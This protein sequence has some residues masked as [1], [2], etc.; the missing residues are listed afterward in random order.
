MFVELL[1]TD[2]YGRRHAF[3]GVLVFADRGHGVVVSFFEQM[4][5]V[6]EHLAVAVKLHRKLAEVAQHLRGEA[7]KRAE[8]PVKLAGGGVG[9]FEQ[10]SDRGY[11]F[12]NPCRKKLLSCWRR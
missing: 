7:V 8:L 3:D 2:I 9:A 12:D 11:E 1:G 6:G 10:L 4:D 5:C